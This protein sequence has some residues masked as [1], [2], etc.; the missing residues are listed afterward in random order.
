MNQRHWGPKQLA[1]RC[2]RW[3]PAK[4]EVTIVIAGHMLPIWRHADGT[5]E[6]PGDEISALPLGI[7]ADTEYRQITISLERGDWLVMY[8]DGISDAR[9]P[10]GDYFT[11]ERIRNHVREADQAKE[12]FD[13]I[14]DGVRQFVGGRPHDDDMCLVCL[15]RV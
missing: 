5:I 13:G 11:I 15:Q 8:T 6:E 3:D 14:I 9:N 7:K 12:A 2:V 4:H 1:R 10:A